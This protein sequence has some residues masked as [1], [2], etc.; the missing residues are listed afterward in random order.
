MKTEYHAVFMVPDT[1]L[2]VAVMAFKRFSVCQF[3]NPTAI[4]AHIAFT[5]GSFEI[6]CNESNERDTQLMM[7]PPKRR[8]NKTIECKHGII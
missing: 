2:N 8:I 3:L 5:T 7:V 4:R 6:Y 1:L